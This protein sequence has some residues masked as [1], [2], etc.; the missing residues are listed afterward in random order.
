[1]A[2]RHNTSI[3]G[4]PLRT[5][6]V[7]I[8]VT[9]E[10]ID[11]SIER[12]SSHCMIAEAVK[13]AVP[14]A[15]H[16]SVDLQTIRFSDPVK[17]IRY[18]YLTPRVAQVPLV[19]YDQGNRPEPFQFKLARGQATPMAAPK[20]LEGKATQA[21]MASARRKARAAGEE[22]DAEKWRAEHAGEL[23]AGDTPNPQHRPRG[24]KKIRESTENSVGCANVTTEGGKPPP[25][26]GFAR[27][28]QFGIR[29]LEI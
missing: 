15:T 21:A 7:W 17:R 2:G 20:T 24:K 4:K 12:D 13:A 19:Q 11:F 22:W 8:E 1:M 10:V 23:P 9:D 5:P 3:Q 6:Q 25:L 29:A 18:I 14:W 27:R 28:R 26:G 16:V